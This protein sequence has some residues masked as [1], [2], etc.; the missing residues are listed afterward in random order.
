MYTS[1]SDLPNATLCTLGNTDQQHSVLNTAQHCAAQPPPP[2]PTYLSTVNLRHTLYTILYVLSS[3]FV[4]WRKHA[5]CISWKRYFTE[6]ISNSRCFFLSVNIFVGTPR[7]PHSSRVTLHNLLIQY[8]RIY[9]L[10][11]TLFGMFVSTLTWNIVTWNYFSGSFGLP[12]TTLSNISFHSAGWMRQSWYSNVSAYPR[13][14]ADH[15]EIIKL[16]ETLRYQG[17]Q[18]GACKGCAN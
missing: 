18:G 1:S 6:G 3:H 13:Q 12:I 16:L 7:T 9:F 4:L 2:V 17:H 14:M 10:V 8:R 11:N 5:K 15:Y